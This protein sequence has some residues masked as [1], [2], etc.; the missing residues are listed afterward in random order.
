MNLAD[1]VEYVAAGSSPAEALRAAFAALALPAVLFAA[2]ALAIV[3]APEPPHVLAPMRQYAP[4]LTYGFGLLIS[5]AFK[6]GRALF[7]ILSLL[8]AHAAFALYVSDARDASAAAIYAALCLFVPLNLAL[9]SLA[10]ERGALNI[11]GVRRVALLGVEIGATAAVVLGGYGAITD[12]VYRPLLVMPALSPV[13]QLGLIVMALALVTSLA[14]AARR[15]G[16]TEAAFAVALAAFA[17][18]CHAAG[19]PETY[20]W[21]TAAGVIVAAGV[22]QDSYRMAFRDELTGLPGRR[23]LNERLMALEGRY[24]IAMIDVD[25]FKQFND[26]WGH[27]VGDQALRLVATRLQRIG[28]GGTAYRYGGEEFCIV[29]QNTRMAMTLPHLE[30]LRRDVAGYAFELRSRA[31]RRGASDRERAERVSRWVSVTVSIGVAARSDY[32]DTPGTVLHAADQA[33]Y[34]AKQSGRNRVYH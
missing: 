30:R 19:A 26:T 32:L 24:T 6:R 28:G 4:V 12:A 9:L 20:A 23:A 25:N 8:I 17:A 13:P 18:A 11:V 7:V 22:L 2:A 5:L 16:V 27:E 3:F 14:C 15:S 29:F 33:L 21:L 34:R 10:R 1:H 31:R